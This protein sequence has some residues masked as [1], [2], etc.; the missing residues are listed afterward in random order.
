MK[1]ISLI[2]AI[3]LTCSGIIAGSESEG[4]LCGMIFIQIP[5]GEFL[6]GSDVSGGEYFDEVPQHIVH[7]D[8]FEIM[9]TEVTQGMWEELMEC[10]TSST[11]HLWTELLGRG[12]DYP[13]YAVSWFECK[14]FIEKMNLLDSTYLYRLPGEAEWEYAC[15]AG[16]EGDFFWGDPQQAESYCCF[17]EEQDD[18]AST[19][20]YGSRETASLEPNSWGLYDMA[21]NVSEWCQD[22]YSPDYDYL[23]VDGTPFMYPCDDQWPVQMNTRRMHRGGSWL[24]DLVQCRSGSRSSEDPGVWATGMGFRLVRVPRT[25][26][27]TALALF[28]E[29]VDSIDADANESADELFTRALELEPG[30]LDALLYR[31][32][33]RHGM[34]MTEESLS[35]FRRAVELAPEDAGAYQMMGVIY[36][37][38]E[39]DDLALKLF[40]RVVELDPDYP[41]IYFHRGLSHFFLCNDEAAIS[42]LSRAIEYNS[43][44][45]TPYY[46]RGTAYLMNEQLGRALDDMNRTIACDPYYGDAYMLRSE[47][48]REMG[49]L[50]Q[51]R[52]DSV[53][54]S[55]L[56]FSGWTKE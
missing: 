8:S 46:A 4:P 14:E 43:G 29:G 41:G 3:L 47:I 44:S 39:R 12:S 56:G 40:N 17:K 32:F 10:D 33:F 22:R 25:S 11:S 31:A 45:P 2:C 48:Y 15:R 49:N 20:V 24:T 53:R 16:S 42:D 37:D 38:I 1:L 9:S 6:I 19:E 51:A 35:D 26:R 7:I 23:P 30:L 5:E 18:P 54:A 52:S 13:A 21:G 55:E 50:E 28:H 27:N 34:G 36:S